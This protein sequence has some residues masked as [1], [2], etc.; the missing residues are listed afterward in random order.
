MPPMSTT[1]EGGEIAHHVV[2]VVGTTLG[3]SSGLQ[4]ITAQV[5]SKGVGKAKH[6]QEGE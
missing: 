6:C 4:A 5:P 1:S 2:H 3:G